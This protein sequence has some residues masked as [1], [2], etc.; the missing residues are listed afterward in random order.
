M[1]QS[2]ELLNRVFTG[3]DS[4]I[5]GYDPE[6]KAQSSQWKSPGSPRPKKRDKVG[7]MW[8]W[9]WW[10][11]SILRVSCI[12]N[13]PLGARQSTRNTI[14]VSLRK[15]RP[16]LWR[17]RNWIL[18]HDNAPA[19]H[20]FSIIEF[21]AKFQIPV[22][23]QPPYS[24]DIAP[25]DFYLFPKLKFLWKD[26][27]LTVLKT[28]RQIRS[29]LLTPLRKKISRNASRVE[30]PL[31]SVCSI[32][33][34][35]LWRRS[36]TIASKYCHFEITRPV[37]KLSNHTSYTILFTMGLINKTEVFIVSIWVM[38]GRARLPSTGTPAGPG[39]IP[40]HVNFLVQVYS[41]GFSSNVR[42]MSGNLGHIHPQVS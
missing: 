2:S 15:K 23:P 17:D 21:L 19:N 30:T 27:D 24:P 7:R 5:Y 40:G 10:S 25:A 26:T 9:W 4:W 35:L 37:F 14:K 12:M 36:I 31:E 32:T 16:A 41:G 13:M 1:T 20:A 39:S 29:G 42:Q 22:L 34:G 38:I 8:R 3:D 6:T 33:S 28:S 18:H 11:F